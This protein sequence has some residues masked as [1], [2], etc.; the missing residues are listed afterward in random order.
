VWLQRPGRLE[1]G[2]RWPLM[3]RI[4]KRLTDGLTLQ[5]VA[6]PLERR[7]KD[8]VI[9]GRGWP[10]RILEIDES[11]H[12]NTYRTLTLEMYPPTEPL[13]FPRREWMQAGEGR[14]PRAGGG[15]GA[16]RPPLF[17][18]AGGRHR[19]RAFRDAL[20]DLL[21]PLYQYAPTLRIAYFE[22]PWIWER[23]APSRMRAVIQDRL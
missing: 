11:Q 12:F 19:Q 8:G 15:W 20:A 2:D 6:P 5:A 10:L 16:P 7:N 23:D 13:A 18:L 21:P 22:V 1:C 14:I 3:Q 17:P 9:G 4:Y